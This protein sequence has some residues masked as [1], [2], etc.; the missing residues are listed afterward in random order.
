MSTNHEFQVHRFNTLTSEQLYA[1]LQ[2]R[3]EVFVVEQNCIFQDLDGYDQQS[4]HVMRY[5]K[6]ELIAYCR[7]LPAQLKYEEWSI[8]RV[9][10]KVSARG[11][12]IAHDLMVFS[13]K[14]IEEK[15]GAAVRLSAQSHLLNFYGSLGFESVGKS[16][17]ED[18]IPHTEMFRMLI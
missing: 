6:D 12:K 16:Y 10:V 2:L 4:Y 1:I 7:I 18:G 17:L 5:E 8:G 11:K 15:K 13:L 9:V 3:S 14:V